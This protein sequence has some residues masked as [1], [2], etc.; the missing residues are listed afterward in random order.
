MHLT[1]L[2][3]SIFVAFNPRGG[4]GGVRGSFI[5]LHN[6]VIHQKHKTGVFRFTSLSNLAIIIE[7]L[8]AKTT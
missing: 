4:G 2:G 7:E 6:F 1:L 5:A 3:L 8:G